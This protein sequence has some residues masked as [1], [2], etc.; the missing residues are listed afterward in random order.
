MVVNEP[1]T[2]LGALEDKESEADWQAEQRD[3]S[4]ALRKLSNSL[5]VTYTPSYPAAYEA[6]D[7]ENEKKRRWGPG[8]G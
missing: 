1:E 6:A 7:K 2:G 4:A 5:M 3:A 8:H